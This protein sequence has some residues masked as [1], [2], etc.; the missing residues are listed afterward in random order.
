MTDLTGKTIGQYQLIEQKGETATTVLCKAFQP[1]FN[2]FV[3]IKLLKPSSARQPDEVHRFR[4]QAD[5]LAL[6]H[7]PR[8]IEVYETGE[9]NGLL[10]RAMRWAD[11]GSLRDLVSLGVQSP[12]YNPQSALALFQGIVE[13][14]EQIHSQGY[15]HGNLTPG[16]VLLDETMQPLLNDFGLPARVGG[17]VS[18]FQAPEQV[19]G[20]MVD[21]RSDVYALGV[22]LYTTLTGVEPPAGVVTSLRA[23][24]PEI[25]DAV[26]RVVFKA[27]AQNPDQ[28]FQSALD[29]LA[30]LK[31]AIET[32][33]PAPPPVYS[34]APSPAA[35]PTQSISQTVTVESEKKGPSVIGI[36]IGVIF[37][38]I[39]C[40][41]AVYSYRA[42]LENQGAVTAQP[43]QPAAQPTQ[44]PPIIILPSQPPA[45]TEV[46]PTREPR[47]TN[48]PVEQ[49]TT[50]PE[51]PEQPPQV[52]QPI[53][54][55]PESSPGAGLLPCGSAGL[56]FLPLA[57]WG[58]SRM[59]KKERI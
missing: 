16:N 55:P 13:G 35:F 10:F 5:L 33:Q 28:R 37:V 31:N 34:P 41:G 3:A 24:R 42:Y 6:F 36:L 38:L 39:L 21:R 26:D 27:L 46:Q 15:V 7:H 43:T 48:P 1:A 20:G 12:F 11:K 23:R 52:E 25:P 57:V 2:R 30:A 19:Q 32:P 53:A 44:A 49:P 29:F 47:P 51:Q 9:A 22:L 18:P 54:T 8:L 58:A 14:I 45:I 50:P 56:V 59:K 4:Q 17:P 40:I